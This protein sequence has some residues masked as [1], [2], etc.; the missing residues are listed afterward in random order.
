MPFKDG[1]LK[2]LAPFPNW[3]K[4]ES[5]SARV[6]TEET[7]LVIKKGVYNVTSIGLVL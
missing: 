6:T 5:K 3:Q 4:R 1:W 7:T 2:N